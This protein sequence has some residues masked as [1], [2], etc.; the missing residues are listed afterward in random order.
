MLKHYSSGIP[1]RRHRWGRVPAFLAAIGL[2]GSASAQNAASYSFT[3]TSGGTLADMTD[4][5]TLIGTGQD[6]ASVSGQAIGFPFTFEGTAYTQYSVNENGNAR[7]GSGDVGGSQIWQVNFDGAP[8]F[9]PFSVDAGTATGGVTTSLEGSEPNR[10]RIVQWSVAVPGWQATANTTFQMLLHEASGA[11]EYRYGTGAADLGDNRVSIFGASSANYL[12]VRPGQVA[13]STDSAPLNQWPGAG[14]SYTFSPPAPCTTPAPGNT[15]A[16]IL[17]GC[18]GLSSNLSLQ[19][20][21]QGS[22][23]SYQWL[24]SPTGGAPWTAVG[25]NAPTYTTA[26]LTATTWFSCEVTCSTGPS[27]VASTP[28][29]I[30]ISDPAATYHVYNGTTITEGFATWGDRCSTADVPSVASNNW[31]NLPAFGPGTWRASNTSQVISGWNNVSG[32]FTS[33][34]VA[35]NPNAQAVTLPAARFHSRQGSS[36]VGTLDYHVD[37]SAGTGNELLRF[38]YINSAGSGNLSVWVSTNGGANFSQI[39]STLTT[40]AINTWET[41][42]FTIGSTS[43]TTVIRLRGTAATTAAGNDIGVDNFRIIPAATCST[44]TALAAIVTGAGS[45][46]VSWNCPSCTGSYILEYGNTGFTPGTGATAGGGTI[47]TSATT[48]TTIAGIANGTYQLYVRQ[49]CGSGSISENSAPTSFNIV[50]G[51]FCAGAIDLDALPLTDWSIVANTTGAQNNYTSSACSANLPGPDVVLYHDVAPGA[52]ISLGLWSSANTFAVAYGG[53]CPGT[54]SLACSPGGYFTAGPNI[55][56]VNDFETLIWTNTGC[57]TE[58]LHVLVDAP[59]TGGA[60]HVFNYSYT[61]PSSVCQAVTGLAATVTG[62]STASITWNATCSD[63]VIVEYGPAGFTPGTDA[64]AGVDGTVIT[65]TGTG[66]TIGGLDLDVA[67]DV[68]VRQDCGNA[69]SNNSS[70]ASFIIRNGDDC[71]RVIV[72]TGGTGSITINTTGA[73]NDVQACDEGNQ[74]GDLL[75]S[76]IVQPGFGIYFTSQP[77]EPYIGQVRLAYGSDCNETTDIHCA[78][79]AVDHFWLNE[80]GIEQTVYLIQ[81][82]SDE[83]ST[84]IEWSYFEEC[85]LYDADQDGINDCDDTC[86][87]L[88]GGIGDACDDD[89]ANTGNDLITEECTCVGTPISVG[90]SGNAATVSIT[91]DANGGQITWTIVDE[92]GMAVAS[93]GPYSGQDNTTVNT[94]VCLPNNFGDCYRLQLTDSFGDGIAGGGWE[95]RDEDGNVVLMDSFSSGPNS[96]SQP[97]QNPAYGQGHT[98]CLPLGPSAITTTNCGVFTNIRQSK[99]YCNEVPGATTYQFEFSDPDAGFSRRIALPRNWVRFSEMYTNPLQPGVVYF[100]R[101]RVDQGLPG[102]ADDHFG[103]GCELGMTAQTNCA[104]LI[105][106]PGSNTHSC[107]VTRTF[108]GSS[109]IWATPV[110]GATTY[111]FRFTHAASGFVRNIDRPSYVCALNWVTL[112]LQDGLTYAVDVDVLVGGVWSG[113]CGPVCDLTISNAPARPELRR[114]EAATSA[115]V[116]LMPNPNN[117]ERVTLIAQGLDVEAGTATITIVDLRGAVLSNITVALAQGAINTVLDLNGLDSGVYLVRISDGTQDNIQ[118]LVIQR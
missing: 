57:N 39:G 49:N 43:A 55:Q 96:P 102:F 23:L 115:D 71:S 98:F 40:T 74:G 86:P 19:N 26:A 88:A 38:E 111:R 105:E 73:N 61:V 118:R 80:T 75:L 60:I 104:A 72:L 45:I 79:G 51:D 35:S 31:K 53:S 69:H 47:V 16:S 22:G 68:Y 62:S 92:F 21:P 93:G 112:P 58:R 5:S 56:V 27:T 30:T 36:V 109:K 94:N 2:L 32:G 81:D 59:S 42:Q 34:T 100:A 63:N 8:T 82:G 78:T 24:S 95:V 25:T 90:C 17:S 28:V 76:Y 48:A 20:P 83:G 64:S 11:V 1:A 50:A 84:T 66:T 65:A 116:R 117:G 103:A 106:S 99:V 3:T 114:I 113:H 29:Q 12:N 14:R 9:L 110:S 85:A 7:L 77:S 10:I 37:L 52:T 13:S 107:G 4:A 101:A 18:A 44:P 89:D 41:K 91:T 70:A 97:S 46:D 87:V 108:G 15:L 54:T 33:T 67:Y 6:F